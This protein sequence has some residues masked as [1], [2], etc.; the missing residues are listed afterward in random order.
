MHSQK[1]PSMK[2]SVTIDA[3]EEIETALAL[4]P[5]PSPDRESWSLIAEQERRRIRKILEHRI[6]VVG[7]RLHDKE[8]D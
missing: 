7:V 6:N 4:D 8:R 1:K 3:W 2:P 5:N